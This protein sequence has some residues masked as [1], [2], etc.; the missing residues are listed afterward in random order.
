VITFLQDVRYAFRLLLKNPGFTAIAVLSLALGIGANSAIFSLAD[1]LLLR[2]L[3]I[4]AP[5]DVMNISTS[6]PDNPFGAVSYPNYL[7]L[8]ARSQSFDG[9]TAFELSTLS[10]A[11]SPQALPQIYAGV[12]ASDNFF[13]ALGVQPIL[14][15]GFLPEEGKVPGRDAVAVISYDF[16]QTQYANDPSAVGRNI[17]VKGVDFTI[18]GVAPQS[19]TGIDQYF[20]PA[21]YLPAMMSQRLNAGTTNP[22]E[23][24]GDHSYSVKARLKP[25]VSREK[26]QAELA[27]LWSSLQEQFPDSNQNLKIVVQTELQTRV[28]REGPDAAL[29]ALLMG[30]VGVV[31]LIACANVASLLLGRARARTREIALRLS[32]GATRSRLLS[33][34][35]TESLLLSLI[36]GA[37]GLWVAYGGILFFRTIPIPSEPPIT[38]VPLLD[39]RV[40]LFSALI[41]VASAVLFGLAPALRTLKPDLV[42]SLKPSDAQGFGGRTIGRNILVVGQ[43]ALSMALLI[44]AGMLLT[45]FR[46]ML[47]SDPGFA[48]DHRLMVGFNTSLVRY[49]PDQTHD[50]YRKLVEQ[51]RELAGVRTASLA[52]SV[53]FLPDQ[54]GVSVVPEG[55]QFPKGQTSESMVGNIVDERYFQT[56]NVAVEHGR[57]FTPDDKAGAPL[58]A[59]VNQE[60]ANAYWPNQEA[61]GKRFHL[62]DAKSPLLQIVGVTRTNKYLFIGE[63]PTKFLYLPFAQN[64]S[65]QMLL[66]VETAGDPGP[67]AAQV[68]DLVRRIDPNQPVFNV[69][70]L[71]TFY[72]QRA[73]EVPWM[74]TKLISTMGL[75][76]LALALVGLYGLIAY[77]VAR[78]TQ[79]IGIRMA[80]GADRRSVLRMILRQGLTLSLFGIA[81]GGVITVAVKKLL[82][83][84]LSGL[85]SL[86]TITLVV[87]PIVLVVVTLAA[88]YIPARRASMVD[89][90]VALRYE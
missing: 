55:Y 73:V 67:A 61:L 9:M 4:L 47:A 77:S 57:A 56:M 41:A 32:L 31:L 22:L 50:F 33:Q 27:A 45:G 48:V 62:N 16:W 36:G 28:S 79:E 1:A 29:I 38:I 25:G 74:I 40:L 12:V 23:N 85:G 35:L 44:A 63:S 17:R 3:P 69:R 84:A 24:R 70:T 88:C 18:V 87:V 59:I 68:R 7:D 60:F 83:A 89:P 78:R 72:E 64:P 34:L 82:T 80:I 42:P 11:T 65:Q 8:R 54:Y 81:V 10:I 20:H 30:L 46:K 51:A 39:A 5:S 13:Q 14:G 53:P 6:T 52:R 76:G 90:M 49:S 66:M 75:M 43:I 19:F 26:A 2:P 86:N 37:L 21:V 71:S 58:V 15:R